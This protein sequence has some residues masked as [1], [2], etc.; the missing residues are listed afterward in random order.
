MLDAYRDLID[1][2]LET[3]AE[4]RGLMEGSSRSSSP[5]AL[6]AVARLRDRD[7]M[8]LDRVQ[9]MIRQSSPLLKTPADSTGG[10]VGEAQALLDEMDV[11]R[12]DLVSILMNLTL[13]DWGREAFLES[14]GAITL[15]DEVEAH[16][17][18]DEAQRALLREMLQD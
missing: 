18:F 16:V 11:A 2:L 5:D 10:A 1:E 4:I 6:G 8:V 17:E 13:K 7:R 15:A 14:G 3:P 9:T 12:G